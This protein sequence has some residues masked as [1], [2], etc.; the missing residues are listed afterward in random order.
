MLRKYCMLLLRLAEPASSTVKLRT[1]IASDGEV[2]Y[3]ML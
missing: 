2:P 1:G 3:G